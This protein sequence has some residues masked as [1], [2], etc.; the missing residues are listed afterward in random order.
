MSDQSKSRGDAQGACGVTQAVIL[1]GGLGLRL[2]AAVR[3]S[4]KPMAVVGGRPVLEH[5][6]GML[7][8]SGIRDIVLCVGYLGEVIREHFA[9]GANWG[10][11]IRYAVERELLG[12]AGAIANARD[13]LDDAPFLAMN[14]DTLLPDIDVVSLARFHAEGSF[15][16]QDRVGTLVVV[17]P[18]DPGAYGVVDLDT[19]KPAILRFREK[20]PV[21]PNAC[22]IS[23][24]LYVLE[25]RVFRYIPRNRPSSIEHDVFPEVLKTDGLWA[26]LHDGFFGDIGTPAG[27]ERMRRYM[28]SRD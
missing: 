2:R 7:C 1:A 23:G 20:A 27:L 10:A 25:Q 6:I 21:R 14:G 26:Y 17:R 4:P 5:Q 3:G 16:A 19:R 18:P 12:T 8:Q 11:R 15:P 28:A 9:D 22:F 24:G 13:L